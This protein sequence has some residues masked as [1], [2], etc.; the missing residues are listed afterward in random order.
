VGTPAHVPLLDIIGWTNKHRLVLDLQTGE[1]NIFYA[2]PSGYPKADL[3]KHK[4]WVCPLFE[5]FL[6]WLY[7]Q[8][9]TDV[10]HLPDSV[11]L[12]TGAPA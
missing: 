9:L 5:P 3:D 2:V 1:G 6:G 10:T 12:P 7:Q 4:V 8:D 11:T